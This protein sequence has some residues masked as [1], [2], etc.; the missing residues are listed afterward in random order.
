MGARVQAA[1]EPE[2]MAWKTFFLRNKPAAYLTDSTRGTNSVWQPL[3]NL[4]Q[5]KSNYGPIVYNKAPSIIKQLAFFVGDAGFQAGLQRYLK[6]HAYGNATWRDLLSAVEATSGKSLKSFGDQY[7][8]RAGMAEVETRLETA[9]GRVSKL[10]LTQKPVRQLPG[11]PGGWWPMKVNVRLGY[12]GRPDAVLS[13]EFAGESAE[14]TGAVGLPAPDYV[15][16]NDGDYGYGLFLPDTKS[17]QWIEANVGSVEDGLLRALLWGALWDLARE[18]RLAPKRFVEIALAATPKESDEQIGSYVSARAAIALTRYTPAAD[19]AQ[20]QPQWEALHASRA[21]DKG[22]AY[23]FRKASLD[24]LVETARTPAAI[25]RLRDYLSGAELFDG[26]PVK[27]L[28]RWNIVQRLVALGEPDAA[29]LLEAEKVHDK[30][31]EAG[32]SAFIAGAAQPSAEVKK[33]Y[34]ARYLDDASLNEEWVSSS[35]SA[36]NDPDQAALTLPYLRP[37]LD[38]LQWI[39][40]HRRIFFLAAWINAFVRGQQSQKAVAEVDRFLS[41]RPDLPIDIKRKVLEARD[42]LER[43]VAIRRAAGADV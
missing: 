28:T 27:Q 42:E 10:V 6:E 12:S 35:L 14:V 4:D 3:A 21:Q 16:A 13:A 17:A 34:F 29:Q 9:D 8:L 43:T 30:T 38:K 37:A 11:D 32:R 24:Q 26:A 20:L 15:W 18:T 39:Q 31:P 33:A 40:Q 25:R 5:A 41:E 2:S 1:L 22:L 36:F 7:I 23:G 19:A